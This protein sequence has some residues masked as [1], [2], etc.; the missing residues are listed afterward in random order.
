MPFHTHILYLDGREEVH[1]T[2]HLFRADGVA[3]MFRILDE[4]G[5]ETCIP[6]PVVRKA[7]TEPIK[8]DSGAP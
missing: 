3:M 6:Y 1:K 4:T 2:R 7:W 8:Q 5:N